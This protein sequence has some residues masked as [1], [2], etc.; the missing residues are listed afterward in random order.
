MGIHK[1]VLVWSASDLSTAPVVGSTFTVTGTSDLMAFKDDEANQV[2]ADFDPIDADQA[3]SGNLEGTEYS[4]NTNTGDV[5][6]FEV[7]FQITD[8]VNTFNIYRIDNGSLG[9]NTT[10]YVSEQTLDPNVTY[11]V[12][13]TDIGVNFN[14][15]TAYEASPNWSD[16]AGHVDGTSGDD[17]IGAGY[18]DDDSDQIDGTDG[19]NDV[20]LGE[21]GGDT[22]S[23]G[24]GDDLIYGDHVEE[25]AAGTTEY[26]V[27]GFIRDLNFELTADHFA[28][29]G[30]TIFDVT[31]NPV[32]I[33]II[34]NDSGAGDD[35]VTSEI[36]T[37]TDQ[38]IEING[39]LYN[40]APDVQHE[41]LGSDGVTYTMMLIDVDRN[42]DGIIDKYDPTSDPGDRNYED[43]QILLPVGTI[44]PPGVTLTSTS[45]GIMSI[46]N[47]DY[48]TLNGGMEITNYD[49]VI[50]AGAGNDT[51]FGG[52]G[53]DTITGG[54][55]DDTFVYN[56]SDGADAIIDFN[57]GN[58]GS[59]DDGD[60]SNN[61]HVDLNG[62]YTLAAKEAIEALGT[63]SFTHELDMLRQDAA[64]GTLDGIIN[65]TDYSA[66][67]SGIDLTL[68]N[69]GAAVTGTDLTFDN[70]NVACFTPG[71]L[72]KTKD[73][74]VPVEELSQGDLVLTMDNG[75]QPIRWIGMRHLSRSDL[76]KT[77]KLR[78]I[79]IRA[80][81][82]GKR[83]PELDLVV[84]P[85]HRILVSSKIAEQMFGQTEVLV[86]SKHLVMLDGIDV[87]DDLAEIV[88]VHFL[89]DR[90][91]VVFS[92]GALTESL[93]T[94]PQ[95]LKSLSPEAKAEILSLFPELTE[96]DYE[97]L[98]CRKLANGRMGRKLAIRH[99]N[100]NKPLVQSEVFGGAQ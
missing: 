60:Q 41:F 24:A 82:L 93:Y 83:T 16:L 58:T 13:Q 86:G 95:A 37:D 53:D 94:G 4:G 26:V 40:F 10:A 30:A 17:V 39:V 99:K 74:D 89:F 5:F 98:S 2:P 87:A 90:H 80:G 44:P 62:F 7:A 67:I 85:Q 21:G 84:S 100:N 20:I 57:A 59:I 18:A 65:G 38:L 78:P 45:A 48:T 91:E 32:E 34:D 22:I 50:D 55:G 23:S 8:G 54:S 3:L 1:D 9:D 71:T 25:L 63:D 42:G 19:I 77:P 31:D 43:G 36:P 81:A 33:R 47:P 97:A 27:Q 56:A 92:N 6:E 73:G 11:T 70:T 76:E 61:D 29:P 72:I 51:V 52:Q 66:T 88:Y 14:N 12:L 96:V 64:D 49:D 69:G 68:Q 75:H 46:S 35:D 15:G 28:S 79:R